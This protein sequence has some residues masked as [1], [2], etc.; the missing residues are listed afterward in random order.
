M[1]NRKASAHRSLPPDI[2]GSLA[3]TLR[4]TRE[5]AAMTQEAVASAAGVSV[6]M[7]RRLEAGTGNPTL[8]TLHAVATALGSDLI[9]LLRP[10]S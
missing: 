8:G 10:S 4:S 3:S 9:G 1:P 5:G 2:A 7:V 6:Q